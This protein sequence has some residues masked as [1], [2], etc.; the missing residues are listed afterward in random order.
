MMVMLLLFVL[1]SIM[2]MTTNRRRPVFCYC[3]CCCCF[4]QLRLL[5]DVK[6]EKEMH[7]KEGKSLWKMALGR[8][9]NDGTS[10]KKSRNPPEIK[11]EQERGATG[12]GEGNAA[13]GGT[14]GGGGGKAE[15]EENEEEEKKTENKKSKKAVRESSF[16]RCS[17]VCLSLSGCMSACLSVHLFR[18][19]R[20]ISQL[21]IFTLSS[22]Y[23]YISIYVQPRIGK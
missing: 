1:F 16:L 7:K 19:Y 13:G 15:D 22:I 3:C 11:K 4:D 20:S 12:N 6:P 8:L 10:P 23:M 14:G 21:S 9:L 17:C 2:M 18:Y 5:E